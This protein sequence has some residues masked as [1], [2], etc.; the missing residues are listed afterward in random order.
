MWLLNI[1]IL[2]WESCQCLVNTRFLFLRVLL[3]SCTVLKQDLGGETHG[4]NQGWRRGRLKWSCILLLCRVMSPELW[5]LSLPVWVDWREVTCWVSANEAVGW[6]YWIGGSF[7]LV[8]GYELLW[9]SFVHGVLCT[10]WDM[11]RRC[12]LLEYFSYY[13]KNVLK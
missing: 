3:N 5:V 1:E 11:H 12:D 2:R 6:F 7:S 10:C 8:N 4:I 13:L 9:H